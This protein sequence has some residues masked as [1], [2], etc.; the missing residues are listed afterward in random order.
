MID[1]LKIPRERISVLIGKYG[2][3]KSVLE[4]S[5]KTKINIDEEV[6]I[7]GEPL[8][9]MSAREIIKAIGRGFSPE[10]AMD[11]LDEN[12][13]LHIIPLEKKRN[14]LIRVKSRLIGTGGKAKRNIEVLTHTKI[15]VYGKTV[16]VIGEYDK[17]EKASKAIE[18]LISGS[19]HRNVYKFLEHYK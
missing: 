13:I 5:T 1:R 10:D 3:I 7:K 9:V 6:T 15:S 11:L 18:K 17:V 19:P 2:N 16:S 4:K 8:E 14:I 12:K